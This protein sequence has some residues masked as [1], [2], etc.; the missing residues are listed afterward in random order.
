MS[1]EEVIP[2]LLLLSGLRSL[3]NTV[4]ASDDGWSRAQ[5]DT[6]ERTIAQSPN[7][8][9]ETDYLLFLWRFV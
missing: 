4:L 3:G 1:S 2:S 6:C 9:T 5:I 7:H 8:N